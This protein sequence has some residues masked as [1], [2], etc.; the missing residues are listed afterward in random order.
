M[1]RE[2]FGDGVRECLAIHRQG[3]AGGKTMTIGHLHDQ[4]AGLAHLPVQQTDRVLLMIVG[5]K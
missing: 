2:L 5:T 3:A 1:C 4:S